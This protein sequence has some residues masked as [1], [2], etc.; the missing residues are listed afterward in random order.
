MAKTKWAK[1][2]KDEQDYM[3]FMIGVLYNYT[4]LLKVGY[5]ATDEE[6]AD[7][8]WA[9]TELTAK[10]NEVMEEDFRKPNCF[11]EAEALQTIV[12]ILNS[13]ERLLWEHTN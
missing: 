1:L 3:A 6:E 2:E 7:R 13:D 12:I 4:D 9:I 8:A 11:T 10:M 5:D